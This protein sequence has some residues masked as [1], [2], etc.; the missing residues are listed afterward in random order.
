MNLSTDS[1]LR[2]LPS[3]REQSLG[4]PRSIVAD[5]RSRVASVRLHNYLMWI[6]LCGIL[7]LS[8]AAE[9]ASKG[10]SDLFEQAPLITFPFAFSE[11][12]T[13]WTLQPDEPNP[14]KLTGSAWWTF[15]APTDGVMDVVLESDSCGIM[16]FDSAESLNQL[17]PKTASTECRGFDNLKCAQI[18][19]KQGYRGFIQIG[20]SSASTCFYS[21]DVAFGKRP[22]NIEES[23]ALEISFPFNSGAQNTRFVSNSKGR[24]LWW[25]FK[26]VDYGVVTGSASSGEENLVIQVYKE[27]SR[28]SA[29]LVS[30]SVQRFIVRPEFTYV[31][32]IGSEKGKEG[33]FRTFSFNLAFE[34]T[35]F[36]NFNSSLAQAIDNLPFEVDQVSS[37][38]GQTYPPQYSV[39]RNALYWKYTPKQAGFIRISISTFANAKI[40]LFDG[41]MKNALAETSSGTS[42]GVFL[43]LEAQVLPGN[44]YFIVVGTIINVPAPKYKLWVESFSKEPKTVE[45]TPE[46]PVQKLDLAWLAYLL[47]PMCL[48]GLVLVVVFV[49]VVLKK[50]QQPATTPLMGMSLTGIN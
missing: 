15:Q 13:S 10:P 41:E 27:H 32:S 9:D 21:V 45:P 3:M 49:V 5:T 4:S 35:K 48:A 37:E 12:S 31:L 29:N 44:A 22:E 14:L 34:K 43:E 42:T 25:K 20:S 8:V 6:V 19:L 2:R 11:D 7:Y 36:K 30:S 1:M 46:A 39:P 38:F 26:P 40:V 33:V 17:V 18:E 23:A 47:V 16:F 24:L 28:S 50:R